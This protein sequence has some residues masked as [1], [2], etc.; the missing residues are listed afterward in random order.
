MIRKGVLLDSLIDAPTIAY[1]LLD[2]NWPGRT[3]R[4]RQRPRVARRVLVFDDYGQLPLKAADGFISARGH[5]MLVELPTGQ[6]SR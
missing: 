5:H 4:W 1:L 6:G 3:P 2:M